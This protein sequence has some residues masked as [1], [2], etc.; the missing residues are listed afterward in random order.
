MENGSLLQ[1]MEADREMLMAALAQNRAPQAAQAAVEKA[2]DRA[3]MRYGEVC[4][5]EASREAAQLVVRTMRSALPL[6]DSVS[7]ARR[8]SREPASARARRGLSPKALGLLAGSAALEVVAMVWVMLTSGRMRSPLSVM[9]ALLPG[10]LALGAAFWAGF[11][12]GRPGAAADDPESREEFL[13]DPDK[14]WHQ[15]Q[16][17][18]LMAD[19]AIERAG[20]EARQQADAAAQAGGDAPNS[21]EIALFSGLLE[22]AYALDG[23][24]ARE[25]IEAI[26][27]H[28]HGMGVE[29]VDFEPGRERWFELLP[30]S[31]PGTLRPALMRGDRVVKKGLAAQ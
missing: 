11:V 23:D 5:D 12:S 27:F 19:D 22:S 28:L 25:M 3:L 21:R 10:A 1:L 15:L 6:M 29:A 14:L 4:D 13:V 31:R 17:M 9:E 16:G 18:L 8:W 2:L 24:D 30:A 20:D 7:E 26:R